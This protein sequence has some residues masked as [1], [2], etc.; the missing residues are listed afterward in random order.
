VISSQNKLFVTARRVNVGTTL[1][2]DGQESTSIKPGDRIVVQRAAKDLLLVE[3]PESREWR[4]L[5]EKL[6]WA[7]SPGYN[8]SPK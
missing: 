5:A 6:N 4:T 8:A 3:N 2:C 7:A 1:F